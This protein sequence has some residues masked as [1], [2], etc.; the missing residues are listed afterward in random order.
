MDPSTTTTVSPFVVAA[1]ISATA[2]IAVPFINHYLTKRREAG[3]ALLYHD[4]FPLE[5]VK[6]A[7]AEATRE[8][9][10]LQTWISHLGDC[11]LAFE[12]AIKRDSNPI[13]PEL[14]KL[15]IRMILMN[16]KNPF[17]E[18]RGL[19]SGWPSANNLAG[20]A[21]NHF[22]T[23]QQ[24]P[25]RQ[26]F[27]LRESDELPTFALFCA[28]DQMFFVP[29]LRGRDTLHSPCIE[30]NARKKGFADDLK[31]HF[32]GLWTSLEPNRTVTQNNGEE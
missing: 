25:G 32:E 31:R 1:A 3:A 28:D 18:A 27:E 16:P 30:V 23:W 9:L 12:Q 15:R 10:I 4:A 5:L 6:K 20:A 8:I 21:L 26:A 22:R 24:K 17:T 2:L 29:Y 19:H 7:L 14:Q 11:C 13:H